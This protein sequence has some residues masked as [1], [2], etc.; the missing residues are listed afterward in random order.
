MG[1][2][3]L[4]PEEISLTYRR[5]AE[6]PPAKRQRTDAGEKVNGADAK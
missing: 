2:K 4:W 6:P 1:L 5:G 3:A